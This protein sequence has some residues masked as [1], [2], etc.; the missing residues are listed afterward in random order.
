MQEVMGKKGKPRR[1][2]ITRHTWLRSRGIIAVSL[3]ERSRA[4]GAMLLNPAKRRLEA[5]NRPTFFNSGAG[6]FKS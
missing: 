1:P 3:Q 5:Q 4:Y 2:C 6:R